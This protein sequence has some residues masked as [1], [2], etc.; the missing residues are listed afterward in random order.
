MST[1]AKIYILVVTFILAFFIGYALSWKAKMNQIDNNIHQMQNIMEQQQ[2]EYNKIR[3][4][5][6]NE[7]G[8]DL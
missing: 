7:L 4:Q 6:I 8:E 3:R 5:Y 2:I 1:G